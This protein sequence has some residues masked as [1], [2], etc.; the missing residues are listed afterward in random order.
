M[1]ENKPVRVNLMLDTQ[2]IE[3]LDLLAAALKQ[4]R[5]ALVRGLVGAAVPQ[6]TQLAHS[7]AELEKANANEFEQRVKRLEQISGK[8]QENV[9][10][11]LDLL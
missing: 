5:S 8:L 6:L 7:V 10:K 3:V 9:N 11:G 4:T 1:K 2:T